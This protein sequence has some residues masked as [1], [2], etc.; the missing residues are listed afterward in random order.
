MGS[1]VTASNKMAHTAHRTALVSLEVCLVLVQQPF[2]F[3]GYS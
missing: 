2:T 3:L 1:T